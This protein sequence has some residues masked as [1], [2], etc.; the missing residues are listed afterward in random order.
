MS[1]FSCHQGGIAVATP[2]A[3]DSTGT[4]W[5]SYIKPSELTAS[6]EYRP[7]RW[8]STL[9]Q[10]Y[11]GEIWASPLDIYGQGTSEEEAKRD[12]WG[13]LEEDYRYLLSNQGRLGQARLDRLREI[14]SI[15]GS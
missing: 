1:R 7:S 3:Q 11:E 4:V 9:L 6:I 5:V 2:V 10:I 15:V 12:W 14:R 8:V 13:N